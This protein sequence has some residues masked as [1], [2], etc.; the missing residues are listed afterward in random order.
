MATTTKALLKLNKI[1]SQLKI[2]IRFSHGEDVE[3]IPQKLGRKRIVDDGQRYAIINISLSYYNF[4]INSKKETE[5][6]LIKTIA[7]ELGHYFVA[8]PKRRRQ[9]D[10]GIKNKSLS[11]KTNDK[12][13]L[14]EIK[15]QAIEREIYDQIGFKTTNKDYRDSVLVKEWW[16]SQGKQLVDNMFYILGI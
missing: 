2:H 13:E 8:P 11:Q 7:H 12:Y 9:K 5:E 14:E 1:L 16:Q 4:L 10:Y 6:Q 3:Y 15:A